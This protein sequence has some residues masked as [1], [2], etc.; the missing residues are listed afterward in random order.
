MTLTPNQ[1]TEYQK[2]LGVLRT[3]YMSGPHNHLPKQIYF[4]TVAMT[5]KLGIPFNFF[6]KKGITEEMRKSLCREIKE[7]AQQ[8]FPNNNNGFTCPWSIGSYDDDLG[9]LGE[10]LGKKSW[11]HSEIFMRESQGKLHVYFNCLSGDRNST[12]LIHS[13]L[14]TALSVIVQEEML[15]ELRK[16]YITMMEG[17]NLAER[18]VQP[19][20]HIDRYAC[21]ELIVR[22]ICSFVA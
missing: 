6:A 7:K 13:T 3:G 8:L 9:S 5:N 19:V 17:V 22:E 14:K 4:E 21:N 20:D 18:S 10:I 2:K 15:W 16:D 12:S 11:S 1:L